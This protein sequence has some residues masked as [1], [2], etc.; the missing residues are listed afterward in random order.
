MSVVVQRL[1]MNAVY[2]MAVALQMALIA[3]VTVWMLVF[4]VLQI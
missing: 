2:V 3:M 1:K 4:A